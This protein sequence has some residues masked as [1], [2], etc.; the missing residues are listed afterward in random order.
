MVARV[1][2][3]NAGDKKLYAFLR[4]LSFDAVGFLRLVSAE[5]RVEVDAA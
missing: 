5:N 3:N 4:K 2:Y 1:V